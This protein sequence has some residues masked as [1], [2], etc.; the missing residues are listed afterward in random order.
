VSCRGWMVEGEF[1]G[2]V[3]GELQEM[4]ECE[5]HDDGRR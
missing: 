2:L 4:I 3:K 5:V 1:Q